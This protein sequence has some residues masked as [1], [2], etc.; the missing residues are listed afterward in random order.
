MFHLLCHRHRHPRFNGG[1]MK[2]RERVLV[3]CACLNAVPPEPI[4]AVWWWWWWRVRVL[5]FQLI[6]NVLRLFTG[7]PVLLLSGM[8]W[9]QVRFFLF[10]AVR[11]LNKWRMVGWRWWWAR[12]ADERNIS[13]AFHFHLTQFL[14]RGHCHCLLEFVRIFMTWCENR[15]PPRGNTNIYDAIHV[16]CFWT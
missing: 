12:R 14:H 5:Q 3:D 15:N 10:I 6:S 11:E 2:E 16:Y 4:G 13:I 9:Q 1:G 8:T 7:R